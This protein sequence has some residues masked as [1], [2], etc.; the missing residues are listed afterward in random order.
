MKRRLVPLLFLLSFAV[1]AA[2]PVRRAEVDLSQGLLAFKGRDYGEA[3]RHFSSALEK[4][5][6]NF[7][8]TYFLG[9]TRYH[10]GKYDEAVALLDQAIQKNSR[11]PESFFYRGLSYYRLKQKEEAIRDF[12]KV[13]EIASPGPMVDLSA[14]YLRR[15]EESGTISEIGRERRWFLFGN[16]GSLSDSN[17]SLNPD[18][19]TLATLPSDRSDVQLSARGGGGYHFLSDERY[20]LSGR[21]SYEHSF[22]LELGEFDY[23]LTTVGVEPSLKRGPWEIGVPFIYQFSFLDGEKYLSRPALAPSVQHLL[24]NRLLSKLA[25][26]GRLDSFFQ[27]VTNPAQNRDAKN[28]NIEFAE[29]LLGDDQGHFLKASYLFEKNWAD[30]ADWD[31]Q[32]HGI[33]FAMKSPLFRKTSFYFYGE[34]FFD[35]KFDHV[36]SVLG[37]R[38]DDFLQAYGLKLTRR[39]VK[40]VDFVGSYDFYR[41]RSNQTFFSYSRH[42]AGGSIAFSF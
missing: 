42:L 22:H 1:E 19:V 17:V 25:V 13:T 31:Y 40:S 14:S 6:E 9:V 3:E 27:T 26:Q 36:D 10:L 5:R 7:S 2:S 16:F 12:K 24:G 34:I 35:R 41:S 8:A 18:G 11:E 21:A 30:G 39:I 33:G 20:R 28:L 15:L 37:S 32:A 38:R 29:Y 4:D 23:G